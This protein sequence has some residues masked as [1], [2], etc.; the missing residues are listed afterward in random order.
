LATK[1]AGPENQKQIKDK[2]YENHGA[3]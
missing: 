3:N 2:R 1:P